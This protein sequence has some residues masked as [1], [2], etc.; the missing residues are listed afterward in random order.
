[1]RGII[2][3]YIEDK[4]VVSKQEI[5]CGFGPPTPQFLRPSTDGHDAE[6]EHRKK[7]SRMS[8]QAMRE[9]SSLRNYSQ[10]GVDY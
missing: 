1:V 2:G 4:R 10:N 7:G 6:Q 3:G 9:P 8:S 5:I